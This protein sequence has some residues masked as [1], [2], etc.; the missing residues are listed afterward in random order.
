MGLALAIDYMLLILSRYRDE[1]ADGA[2]RDEALIS[3]MATAGRTVLFSAMTVA[4]SM[5]T[6]VLFPQYFLKSFAYAG[7]AV[8]AFAAAAAVVAFAA[9][10]AVVVTPAAIKLLGPRLD[11]M[12]VRRLLRRVLGRP[13]PQR[14]PVEQSFW[15]RSSKLAMRRALPTGAAIIALLLVL[16]APFLGVKWGFPDDRVLPKSASAHQV[17]DQLR[18]E[19]AVDSATNVTVVIPDAGGV[20]PADLSRYS[21]A[22]SR[23]P[24]VTSVSSPDGAFVD[25]APVGPPPAPTAAK[26]GSAFLTVGSSAPLFSDASA[27]QLQR[28]HAVATPGGEH[29][30]RSVDGLRGVPDLADPRV[31]ARIGS[32]TARQRRERGAWRGPHRAGDHGGGAVDVDLVC[33]VDSRAG[34]V[35]AD[36]RAGF[37]ACGAGRRHAGA[38]AARPRVHARSRPRELVGAETV[39]P[40]A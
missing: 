37:D 14:K 39:G 1:L 8:V 18:S 9:A 10:A 30:V 13:E 32:D 25:G 24:D 21:A 19:F 40:A 6:M 20:T 28:L 34:V 15:Y 7:V 2:D 27:T 31:L 38:D 36:V 11:S 33:G 3:T 26:N 16:G 29:L 23:V 35:H 22:L 4:L 5:I 17:G 12:G